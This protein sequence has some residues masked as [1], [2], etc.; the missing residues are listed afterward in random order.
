M[1]QSSHTRELT[2]APSGA[3]S[4]A[5]AGGTPKLPRGRVPRTPR[6]FYSLR[7]YQRYMESQVTLEWLKEFWGRIGVEV[8]TDDEVGYQRAKAFSESVG[9]EWGQDWYRVYQGKVY[10]N[11][12]KEP[13]SATRACGIEPPRKIGEEGN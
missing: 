6:V 2:S 7:E 9:L 1:M 5:S 4:T 8:I 10:V 3:A 12:T 13:T 11:K